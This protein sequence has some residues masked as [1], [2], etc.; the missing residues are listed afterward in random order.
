MPSADTYSIAA[1]SP[2]ACAIGGVPA[3]KR[4]GGGAKVEPVILTTSIISPP[5]RNGGSDSSRS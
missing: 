3:S 2:T 4:Y 1:P 5:P